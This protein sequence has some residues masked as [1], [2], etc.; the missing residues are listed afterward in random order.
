MVCC[1]N[2]MVCTNSLFVFLLNYQ[3]VIDQNIKRLNGQFI[4]FT[5]LIQMKASDESVA[6]LTF[7]K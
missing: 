3:F 5:D 2:Y 4:F 7:N 1:S 6:N